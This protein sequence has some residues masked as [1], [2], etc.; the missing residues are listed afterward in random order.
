MTVN[1]D[2]PGRWKA[3]IA[4]SVDYFNRWFIAF[5]PETFRSTRVTTTEHVKRALHVTD[6]LRRLDVNALIADRLCSAVANPII[7]N[8]QEHLG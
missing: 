6:D 5:A 1:A 8:A 4:A 7:R 2:K 3:D